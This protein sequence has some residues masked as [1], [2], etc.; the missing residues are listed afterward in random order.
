MSPKT[1]RLGK[2]LRNISQRGICIYREKTMRARLSPLEILRRRFPGWRASRCGTKTGHV[3]DTL[4]GLP[5]ID[6]SPPPRGWTLPG[7]ADGCR[8]TSMLARATSQPVTTEGE[9]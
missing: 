8:A 6:A 7:D 1:E 4:A 5:R 9:P 2:R 3:S